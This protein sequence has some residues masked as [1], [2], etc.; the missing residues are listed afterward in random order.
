[1]SFV[2]SLKNGE[3]EASKY[4]TFIVAGPSLSLDCES[5]LTPSS[6]GFNFRIHVNLLAKWVA[7]SLTALWNVCGKSTLHTIPYVLH[8][9]HQ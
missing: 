1:M 5:T 3:T 7:V 4:T 8:V 6:F 9:G 2:A